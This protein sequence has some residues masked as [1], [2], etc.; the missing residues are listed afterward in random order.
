MAKNVLVLNDEE[1]SLGELIEGLQA[2]G[3]T[4]YST[5]NADDCIDKF[6]EI[7]P[8]A[9]YFSLKTIGVLDSLQVIRMDPEGATVPIIFF[10]TGKETIKN[11]KTAKDRGG[12]GF[13]KYPVD[14]AKVVQSCK[15][16]IGPGDPNAPLPDEGGAPEPEPVPEPVEEAP[17]EEEKTPEETLEGAADELLGQLQEAEAAAEAP[18]AEAPAEPA[19]EAPAAPGADPALLDAA[20]QRAQELENELAALKVQLEEQA[21]AAAELQAALASGDEARIAAARAA[22]EVC[23]A[24]TAEAEAAA[25]LQAA[26]ASGDAARIAAAQAALEVCKAK[27]AEAEAAAERLQDAAADGRR[28][29]RQPGDGSGGWMP[30]RTAFSLRSAG[31]CSARLLGGSA[32]GITHSLR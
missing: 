25:E 23:Q 8:K 26:L 1:N 30:L 11:E 24:K 7:S 27:T 20:N 32:R 13:F 31:G 5:T 15:K 3:Y 2:A 19:A 17:A 22:L 12:D 16:A 14:V 4:A 28:L 6:D 10:G 18:A 29:G 9:L 21:K